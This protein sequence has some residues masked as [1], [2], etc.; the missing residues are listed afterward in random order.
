MAE[1][2]RAY[3]YYTPA[4][5]GHVGVILERENRKKL[6]PGY[7]YDPISDEAFVFRLVTSKGELLGWVADVIEEALLL[8]WEE[9][10]E[11][12]IIDQEYAPEGCRLKELV[13][14]VYEKNKPTP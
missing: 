7:D 13:R 8:D 2:Y 6:R 5:S 3:S 9:E 11:A 4:L 10:P 12:L 14:R 1:K